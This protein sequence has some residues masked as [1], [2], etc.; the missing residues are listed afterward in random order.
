M[1]ASTLDTATVL[2]ER[3]V[4]EQASTAMPF[5]A[6]SGQTV[7]GKYHFASWLLAS[8]QTLTARLTCCSTAE[9]S[10]SRRADGQFQRRGVQQTSTRPI[11]IPRGGNTA[12]RRGRSNEDPP[13]PQNTVPNTIDIG[14]QRGIATLA[15]FAEARARHRVR[16]DLYPDPPQPPPFNRVPNSGDN[17]GRMSTMPN[18]PDV[19]VFR[20]DHYS[21]S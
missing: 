2:V 19:Y 8:L 12:T 14:R 10:H 4:I 16:P 21:T 9:S 3:R 6:E 20:Q 1:K 18:I 5:E 17:L 7:R 15:E 13:Y 11:D